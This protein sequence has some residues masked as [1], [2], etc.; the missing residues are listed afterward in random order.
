MKCTDTY[1]TTRT[2]DVVILKNWDRFHTNVVDPAA[3]P[4][5]VIAKK[6]KKGPEFMNLAGSYYRRC[7]CPDVSAGGVSAGRFFWQQQKKSDK[8]EYCEARSNA[9]YGSEEDP[10]VFLGQKLDAGEATQLK[11]AMQKSCRGEPVRPPP[12]MPMLAKGADW[13]EF[14][15]TLGAIER[16]Q[17]KRDSHL[18]QPT[19]TAMAYP[20]PLDPYLQNQLY[21]DDGVW[22][23]G[24]H[25]ALNADRFVHADLMKELNKTLKIWMNGCPKSVPTLLPTSNGGAT[26][27][28]YML[29]AALIVTVGCM[30]ALC[31]G[32]YWKFGSAIAATYGM[33]K[34]TEEQVRE[35]ELG[36]TLSR[37]G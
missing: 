31:Y 13:L 11:W 23:L 19:M 33:P 24:C 21:D 9:G 32:V 25:D 7:A 2:V 28:Y 29:V 37:K 18:S 15:V 4:A 8:L 5:L 14:F 12:G 27:R 20:I 26:V 34:P 22:L 1:D 10:E 16:H 17:V 35:V 3:V 30:P 36:E 6:S